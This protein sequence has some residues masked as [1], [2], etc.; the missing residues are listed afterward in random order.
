MCLCG[1]LM[2]FILIQFLLILISFILGSIPASS[3]VQSLIYP[4]KVSEQGYFSLPEIVLCELP[5]SGVRHLEN[6][7]FPQKSVSP[8]ILIRS[9]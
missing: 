8:A 1:M 6:D 9:F 3:V 2:N 7:R 5:A 4:H